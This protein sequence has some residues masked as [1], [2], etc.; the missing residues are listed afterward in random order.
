VAKKAKAGRP[1][2]PVARRLC[3]HFEGGVLAGCARAGL[4]ALQ[5][6]HRTRI[7]LE[8]VAACSVDLDTCRRP[9]EPDA[10]RWD[11]VVVLLDGN[12]AIA[13]EPHPAAA[14]QV[15]EM[16]RKQR[17][18]IEILA[19]EAPLLRIVAWVWLTSSEDEPFFARHHAATRRLAEAGIKYPMVTLDFDRYTRG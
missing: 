11:Y 5:H 19:R 14:D 13:I 7:R 16:L 6:D 1:K 10:D 4:E 8:T 15:D 18:A 12:D 3:H 17:W 9:H 2:R